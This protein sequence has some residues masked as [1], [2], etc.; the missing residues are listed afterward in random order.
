[1][2]CRICKTEAERRHSNQHRKSCRQ[3]LPRVFRPNVQLFFEDGREGQQP[4][5]V[6]DGSIFKL[7]SPIFGSLSNFQLPQ[8]LA[9]PYCPNTM[10]GT[11][12][13]PTFV[14]VLAVAVLIGALIVQRIL[15]L[16][17]PS[18]SALPGPVG[19][20]FLGHVPY[21]TKQPWVM[22]DHWASVYGGIYQLVSL[23]DFSTTL[24]AVLSRLLQESDAILSISAYGTSHLSSSL[25]P[26][27]LSG[28]L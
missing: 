15:D 10:F 1:M 14:G 13:T 22:F 21:L 5:A 9:D 12:L 2:T 26:S 8:I 28:S 25:T 7:E 6:L 4:V 23:Y 17:N 19:F 3:H 24:V 11:Q 20:P 27:S 18:K 16:L